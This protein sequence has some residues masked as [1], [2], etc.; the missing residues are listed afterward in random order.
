MGKGVVKAFFWLAVV[1]GLLFRTILYRTINFYSRP[2]VK[3]FR[4]RCGWNSW[5]VVLVRAISVVNTNR[6]VG[7]RIDRTCTY[8][9]CSDASRQGASQSRAPPR[10]EAT[11]AA[12]AAISSQHDR[13]VANRLPQQYQ[14]QPQQQQQPSNLHQHQ[15]RPTYND[16]ATANKVLRRRVLSEVAYCEYLRVISHF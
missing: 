1:I 12:A 8:R 7:L 14:Q 16:D 6:R 5:H 15:Q 2:S 13:I 9:M 4:I 3:Y 11:A 10:S